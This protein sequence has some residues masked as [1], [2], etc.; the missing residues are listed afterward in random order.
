LKKSTLFILMIGLL[1]IKG[2]A[3]PWMNCGLGAIAFPN[4]RVGAVIS[5]LIWDLGSTATTSA[6][7]SP[8]TCEGKSAQAAM[9]INETYT[10]LEEE[11]VKGSGDH[12]NAMLTLLSCDLNQQDDIISNIRSDFS[13]QL[14]D[15]SLTQTKKAEAYYHLVTSHTSTVCTI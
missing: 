5:N 3:N 12:I 6:M 10:S 2:F 1:S 11:T 13:K 8:D 9:F 4:H 7:S 15:A 14:T